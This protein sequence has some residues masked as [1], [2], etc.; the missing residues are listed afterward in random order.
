MS[1]KLRQELERRIA[2]AAIK[3]LLEAGF[4]IEVDNGEDET[5]KLRDATKLDA[6]LMQTDEDFLYV[7][8]SPKAVN[9]MGWVKLVYG[10]DISDYTVNLETYLTE[11]DKI[12]DKYAD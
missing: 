4:Y 9:P 2:N 7:Y 10:N 8:H 12:A 5:P 6:A 1:V 11:A 3:Q